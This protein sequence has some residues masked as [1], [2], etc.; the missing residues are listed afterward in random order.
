MPYDRTKNAPFYDAQLAL[1]DFGRRGDLKKLRKAYED[2]RT[3]LFRCVRQEGRLDRNL[4]AFFES[5]II[6]VV[7]GYICNSLVSSSPKPP[8]KNM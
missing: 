5:G 6:T 7:S 8:P 3:F 4:D 2:T 1:E